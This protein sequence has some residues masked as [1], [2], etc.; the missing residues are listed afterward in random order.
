VARQLLMHGANSIR[1]RPCALASSNQVVEAFA[2]D[3]T[4][5]TLGQRAEARRASVQTLVKS[6]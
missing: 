6:W 1:H 3:S 4:V 2:L 5:A